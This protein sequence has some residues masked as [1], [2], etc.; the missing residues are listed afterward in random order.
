MYKNYVKRVL[1]HEKIEPMLSAFP[2]VQASQLAEFDPVEEDGL[3][4]EAKKELIE[5]RKALENNNSVFNQR[6]ALEVLGDI[7]GNYESLTRSGKNQSD[8]VSNFLPNPFG[9]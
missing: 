5:R 8:A 4:E 6:F 1:K 2:D 7:I 3:T 9:D